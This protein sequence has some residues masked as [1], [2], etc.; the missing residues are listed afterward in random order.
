[1]VGGT[2]EDLLKLHPVDEGDIFSYY[3]CTYD[4]L[5]SLELE[6][7]VHLRPLDQ[8]LYISYVEISKIT[9]NRRLAVENLRRELSLA[10]EYLRRHPKIKYVVSLTW[11]ASYM[12]ALGMRKSRV[13]VE[14]SA[15]RGEIE[16]INV[17]V[18][19]YL[20]GSNRTP[21]LDSFVERMMAGEFA[22]EDVAYWYCRAKE[23]GG[24]LLK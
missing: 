22:I 15:M 8:I 16:A 2:L 14:A 10:Q 9:G 7:R 17:Q 21:M 1:M 11:L 24:R 3:H 20:T 12:K 23:F 19:D 4:R 5:R 18:F 6:P 13:A